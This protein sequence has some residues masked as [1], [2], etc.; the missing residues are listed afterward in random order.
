MAFVS[1]TSEPAPA[2]LRTVAGSSSAAIVSFQVVVF[3]GWLI[4]LLAPFAIPDPFDLGPA[5]SWTAICLAA[6]LLTWLPDLA[7]GAWPSTP[8]DPILAA[9]AVIVALTSSISV[10]HHQTLIAVLACL[11]NVAIFY[12]TVAI[13]RKES[14]TIERVLVFIVFAIA[15]LLLLATAYHAELGLATRPAEYPIPEGWSG[16]P[17]LSTLG[18]VQFGLLA[19]A[20]QTAGTFWIAVAASGLL[21]VNVLEI[22][23]LYNRAALVA[24]PVVAA[25]GVAATLRPGRWK[26]V[27]LVPALVVVLGSIAAV[28]NPTLRFLAY[29]TVTGNPGGD[30]AGFVPGVAVPESRLQIWQRTI[31]M[32]GDYSI[33]GVGIGNFRQVFEST[34]NP[35]LNPDGRRG[36]HA[37]NL[38]LQQAAELGVPGGLIYLLL[39][40]AILV[41]GWRAARSNASFVTVGLLL[42]IG[43][44]ALSNVATNMFFLTGSAS[45]RLHS[46]T[47]MLFGLVAAISGTRR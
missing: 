18:L 36:V 33:H 29:R 32:I 24:I 11:G 5:L 41:R 23:F 3:S 19:A 7:A 13:A 1:E 43:G 35:E 8:F 31:R 22:V 2:G 40:I 25:L 9:Y 39:W 46:M 16:Y 20:V 45:G 28:S 44:L 10:N 26:R 14:A 27:L 12:A 15:L 34:Y 21:L 17:E 38:W 6:A 47:W 4:L 30:E 37:H 42:A